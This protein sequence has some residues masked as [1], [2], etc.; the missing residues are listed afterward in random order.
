MHALNSEKLNDK[1][2]I[3]G[4]PFLSNS[5]DSRIE[6]WRSCCCCWWF[7]WEFLLRIFLFLLFRSQFTHFFLP[8]LIDSRGWDVEQWQEL[9][10][11]NVFECNIRFVA[12]SRM[13][14]DFNFIF[15]LLLCVFVL[16]WKKRRKTKHIRHW[17]ELP[18]EKNSQLIL[19]S[20]CFSLSQFFLFFAI[21]IG[22]DDFV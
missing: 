8:K 20:M 15:V 13:T 11:V 1:K 9:L 14:I 10:L 2:N 4:R 12:R 19:F 16:A 3:K 5:W 22:C 18:H 6:K 17:L 7:K 21:V